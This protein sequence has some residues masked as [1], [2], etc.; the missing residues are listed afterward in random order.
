LLSR[1]P[2]LLSPVWLPRLHSLSIMAGAAVVLGLIVIVMGI[3]ERSSQNVSE[4][5]TEAIRAVQAE[6]EIGILQD[7][8]QDRAE[9][10]LAGAEFAAL[11]P[12]DQAA[13]RADLSRSDLAP[14][15][16][17]LPATALHLSLAEAALFQRSFDL[18]EA[19]LGAFFVTENE[20]E[21]RAMRLAVGATATALE[22][23]FAS[24]TVERFRV[25]RERLDNLRVQTT[26]ITP[27]LVVEAHQ[28]L[29]ESLRT[30]DRFRQVIIAVTTLIAM[31]ILGITLLV[32]RQLSGALAEANRDREAARSASEGLQ[33]RN[34]QLNA[35][36]SV[37]A[38][39]TDTLSLRYV[40]DAALREALKLMSADS[41]SLRLL[42]GNELVVAGSLTASGANWEGI[43]SVPLGESLAGRVAKRGRTL[44]IDDNVEDRVADDQVDG[45]RELAARSCLIVPLIVGARVV[46]T[47]G[48]WSRQ[49]SAFSADDER[50]IEMMASQVAIAVA[51]ADSTETSERRAHNDTLTGLPNRRQL[52][53]D[54]AGRLSG[55]AASG[56]KA[57][58]AMVDIDS[59]KRFNDDFGHRVGDVTLQKV[60]TV[61]RSAVRGEDVVYR[62]GGE[63]FVI[64]FADAGGEEA[65]ALAERVRT[66][67]ASTPLT[68]DQ[69]EPVGPITVSIGLALLPDHGLDLAELIDIAD[70]A[71]YQSKQSG[72]NR[73]TL[74][75]SAAATIDA[76]A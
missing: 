46:G 53:E 68:G 57:V 21:T 64:V 31:A 72:R 42:K 6:V 7:V 40:I 60:A 48:C 10:Y 61:L 56:G 34:D 38:E 45:V 55:L 17:A 14:A 66:A 65:V 9:S 52:N 22:G 2:N 73:V 8:L 36:Y 39:I 19:Q 3:I 67:V 30:V 25:L 74:W 13:V 4:E 62:Y 76:A 71:M 43:R 35:L 69:L 70:R 29:G 28:H 1:L 15:D 23:Y 51:A 41:V 27:L 59:F 12:V 32:H 49:P 75:R 47:L 54:V 37:F 33:H 44:R 11:S 20:L 58:I 16:A 63:E 5:S 18:I 50:M 26:E 24:P